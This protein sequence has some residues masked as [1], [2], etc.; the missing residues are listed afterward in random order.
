MVASRKVAIKVLR[1]APAHDRDLHQRVKEVCP[2]LNF[3]FHYFNK[4]QELID[5][6]RR[7]LELKH[8]NVLRFYGIIYD[9]GYLP[10]IVS[11]YCNAGSILEYISDVKASDK[12]K[13]ELVGFR[14]NLQDLVILISHSGL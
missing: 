1:G 6:G 9:Y 13:L 4:L 2:I 7:W 3:F 8:P 12:R 5:A 10:A 14:L 11:T